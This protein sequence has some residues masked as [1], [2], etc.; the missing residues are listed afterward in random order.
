MFPARSRNATSR[1]KAAARQPDHVREAQQLLL[2]L[3][4]AFVLAMLLAWPQRLPAQ[5]TVTASS[6]GTHTVRVGETLWSLA[7]R[8]YGDGHKWRDL[9]AMNG[10]AEGGERG[11]AVGQVLRV[12]TSTPPLAEARAALAEAPPSRTPRAATTPAGRV[13]PRPGDAIEGAVPPAAEAPKTEAPKTEAPKTEAPATEPAKT[14]A[15]KTEASKTEAPKTEAPKT[16]APKVEEPTVTAAVAPLSPVPAPRVETPAASTEEPRVERRIGLVRQT[17]LA[18]ARGRD[19]AT[20]FIGPAPFDKDTMSGTIW[21][22]GD[23]TFVAPATRRVGEFHAAP[24]AL[25]DSAWR[26]AGRVNVRALATGSS[27]GRGVHRMQQSDLVEV[28]LPAGADSTPGTQFVAVTA[29]SDL[30]RGARLAL[31]TG[32]LTLETPRDGVPIAR[33]RRL[34]GVIEQG[35]ALLPYVEAPDAP[36]PETV[37]P[38]EA[39]V[40]WI[41][42]APL[43]P[44]LL[45]YL[46]LSTD[47]IGEVQTGDRFQLLAD[48]PP[49]ARVAT[50][51]VVRVTAEGAT[52]IVVGHEQPGIK[53]GM[54]AVRVGRA[55]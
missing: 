32:V 31:P 52:A 27:A 29:G 28:T 4:L 49:G 3:M 37:S 42:D 54:R 19:N 15:P 36:S 45:A 9:A 12:P 17:D 6:S 35:Q 25:A 51:R 39:T 47:E 50:V 34:Y 14:E 41:T 53:V 16:E 24:I 38:V 43:L 5:A 2:P 13:E 23:E 1:V 10:L 7:A 22:S 30:G 48:D 18:R 11:I 26:S 8:Y 46:V 20:V 21:L 33:V 55:P 40:R 44:S